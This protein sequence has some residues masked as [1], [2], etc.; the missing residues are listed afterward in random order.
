M[1]NRLTELPLVVKV[2]KWR[3]NLSSWRILCQSSACRFST[4]KSKK[5]QNK[6]QPPFSRFFT[7][8]MTAW[9][10]CGHRRLSFCKCSAF[11]LHL[12]CLSSESKLDTQFFLNSQSWTTFIG[13]WLCSMIT[14]I[15]VTLRQ[16]S[17][18]FFIFTPFWRE[19]DLKS[20]SFHY[21]C[22]SLLFLWFPSPDC[23]D[24][25]GSYRRTDK[26]NIEYSCGSV[27]RASIWHAGG[28]GSN[29]CA[30]KSMT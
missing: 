5:I 8:I 24:T 25:S 29:P 13:A 2:R 12:V 20:S 15:T 4:H 7:T 28:P 22:T 23:R 9:L 16:I 1:K 14:S 10:C 11:A 26:L 18:H 6:E 19:E 21:P 30:R 27:G 17:F 3:K